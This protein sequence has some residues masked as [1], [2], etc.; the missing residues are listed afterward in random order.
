MPKSTPLICFITG[1]MNQNRSQGGKGPVSLLGNYNN[2]NSD[3]QMPFNTN[4]DDG[5]NSGYHGNQGNYDDSG[6]QVCY[7]PGEIMSFTVMIIC[8]A[9]P[10]EEEGVY[11]FAPV[12]PSVICNLVRLITRVMFGPVFSNFIQILVKESRC[13]LLILGSIG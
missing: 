4:N 7:L 3:G 2:N 11:S 5:N 8:Y 1:S 10:F 13:S 6:Y 9:P 12:C